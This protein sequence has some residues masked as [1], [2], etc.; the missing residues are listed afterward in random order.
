MPESIRITSPNKEVELKIARVECICV[1][2]EGAQCWSSYIL[3]GFTSIYET[4]Y[5]K[6][7]SAVAQQVIFLYQVTLVVPRAVHCGKVM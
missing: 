1:L 5:V 3:K 6:K 2:I 4:Y 7:L